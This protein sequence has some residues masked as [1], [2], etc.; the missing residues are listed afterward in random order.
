MAHSGAMRGWCSAAVM[1]IL[2]GCAAARRG[3]GVDIAAVPVALRPDYE[4]F[5]NRCS[6]CHTLARPLNARV[7]S[8]S[9]WTTYVQRMR[10]QPGSGI[11]QEDTAGILRFLAWYTENRQREGVR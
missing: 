1:V 8:V 11:S 10:R 7:R 5:A 2:T 6:R 4:L 9:H 3:E